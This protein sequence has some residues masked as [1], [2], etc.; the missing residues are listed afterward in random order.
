MYMHDAPVKGSDP[1]TTIAIAEK[2]S[3]PELLHSPWEWIRFDF[4]VNESSYSTLR[5]EQKCAVVVFTQKLDAVRL[6]VQRIEF[7]WTRLPSP[8]PIRYS[9]PEIALAVLIQI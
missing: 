8:K 7:W 5:N 9:S 4:S 2:P 6:S 3:G 1:H